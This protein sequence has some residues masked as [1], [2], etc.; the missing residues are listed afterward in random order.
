MRIKIFILGLGC[1][2]L[3]SCYLF[4]PEEEITTVQIQGEVTDTTNSSP[5]IGARVTLTM[6]RQGAK[7]SMTSTYLMTSSYPDYLRTQ[8]T[9]QQGCYFLQD[10]QVKSCDEKFLSIKAEKNGYYSHEKNVQCIEQLQIINLKLKP[11]N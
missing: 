1:L 10:V 2:F 3:I 9:D 7:G 5:V 11:I 4:E 6:S 8:E